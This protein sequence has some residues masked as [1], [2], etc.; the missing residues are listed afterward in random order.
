MLR[1]ALTISGVCDISIRACT[2]AG[3]GSLFIVANPTFACSSGFAM[4][5]ARSE[6]DFVSMVASDCGSTVD[7]RPVPM[8]AASTAGE[9]V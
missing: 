2:A 9:S 3:S 5:I 4:G 7:Q 8:C 1:I 6:G